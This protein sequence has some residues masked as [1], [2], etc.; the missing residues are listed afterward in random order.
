MDSDRK[1]PLP[2]Y[3]RGRK[4]VCLLLRKAVTHAIVVEF[5]QPSHGEVPKWLKGRVC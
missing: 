4:H 3:W 1:T 2:D 5:T